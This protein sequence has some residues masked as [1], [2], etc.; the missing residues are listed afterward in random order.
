MW[1]GVTDS[2]TLHGHNKYNYIVYLKYT[3][4][5]VLTELYQY[6]VLLYDSIT[7]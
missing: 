5:V 4:V 2:D 3:M 1:F 6:G 7:M